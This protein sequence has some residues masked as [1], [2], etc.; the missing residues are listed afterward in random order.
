MNEITI[1]EMTEKQIY[2]IEDIKTSNPRR[3]FRR[4]GARLQTLLVHGMRK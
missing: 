4:L 1:S 3:L 2:T